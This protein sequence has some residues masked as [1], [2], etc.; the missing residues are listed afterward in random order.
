MLALTPVRQLFQ[1]VRLSQVETVS[2]SRVKLATRPVTL[3]KQ[4]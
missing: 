2:D 1:I 3:T 4:K